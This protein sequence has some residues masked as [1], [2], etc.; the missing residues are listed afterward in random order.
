ME[1]N[2][3]IEN[4]EDIKYIKNYKSNKIDDLIRTAISIG[5]KS[6]VIK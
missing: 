4:Q 5:L 2:I 6:N 3:L 1:L